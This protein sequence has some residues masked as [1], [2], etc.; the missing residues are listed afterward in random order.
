MRDSLLGIDIGNTMIKAVLF[1]LQGGILNAAECAGE[2]HQPQAGFAERSIEEIYSGVTQAIRQCLDHPQAGEWRIIGIGAAGHG[3][4]LYA[5]DRERQ[6]LLGI[7]SID[8]RAIESV[9]ALESSGRSQAIYQ[10]SLQKP[11][12]AATPVLLN[13]LQRHQADVYERIGHIMLAKDVVVHFLTDA[14]STDFSDASGAGLI[15]INLQ[16]YSPDLLALYQIE[17]Q[18]SHLPPLHAS[19]DV[20]GFVSSKTASLTGLTAGI[21]VVAGLFDVV[22]SAAGAAVVNKGEA[23]IVAGTWSINQAIVDNPH[24][25]RPIS[26]NALIEHDR[27][28]AIEASATSAANL[29]WFI[30]EFDD[31]R[32]GQGAAR[33]S[34]M[35]AAVAPHVQLPIYHPYLY[36]GRKDGPA[37]AGF[38]G[39]SGWHSRADML[40]ALF[41]GVIFAH[42]GHINRLRA[43]GI[44][45]L[46]ATLS[47][48]AAKSCIWPQMFADVLGIPLRVAQCH[49]TGALGAAMCAGV[50]IGQW[51]D[52]SDAAHH[53]VKLKPQ[54]LQPDNERHQFHQQRYQLFKRLET[55]MSKVWQE[56][57]RH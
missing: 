34:E 26:M 1:D 3:N 7:Q 10:C 43:A 49:E 35:V 51:H 2:T 20:V 32:N 33:S 56:D 24:Y 52:L 48:G 28:M 18:L 15:D 11:W 54:I 13:W 41:E 19:C 16:D 6:P 46:Q 30:R 9:L 42:Q 8:S 53:A 5:L 37:K 36:S 45:F 22:A 47:G 12:A 40:Y 17:D 25:L 29:D 44:P 14:I 39:L 21:P 4:G 31:G 38:Y 50:G 23:S 27:Y 55:A 57:P